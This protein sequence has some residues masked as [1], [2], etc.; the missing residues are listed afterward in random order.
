MPRFTT[1]MCPKPAIVDCVFRG[2]VKYKFS[3]VNRTWIFC[4][5]LR[6]PLIEVKK[7]RLRGMLDISKTRILVEQE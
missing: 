2:N 6:R 1:L 3:I 5:E 7:N 4:L